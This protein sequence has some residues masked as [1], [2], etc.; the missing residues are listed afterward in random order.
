MLQAL[1]VIRQ[2]TEKEAL[3]IQRAYM[4]LRLVI[5]GK[6]VYVIIMLMI[7]NKIVS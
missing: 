5:P 1:E 6:V 7:R 4:R 3:K 2:L